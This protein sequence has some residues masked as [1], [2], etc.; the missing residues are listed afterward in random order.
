MAL[1]W[2][3]EYSPTRFRDVVEADAPSS[4]DRIRNDDRIR[5]CRFR[6]PCRRR[7]RR[8][9]SPH[10]VALHRDRIVRF[11]YISSRIKPEVGETT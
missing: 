3:S 5:Q 9:A 7:R 2:K 1:R 10:R 6:Q 11:Y 8:R 4:T